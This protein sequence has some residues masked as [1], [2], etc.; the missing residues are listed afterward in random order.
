M[1]F[2]TV[3]SRSFQFDRLI[4]SVDIA[5]G[6]NKID[7]EIF[8]QIGTSN[9]KPKNF[10]YTDFLDKAD[11]NSYIEKCD[12]VITHGGTGVIINSVKKRKKVIAVPRLAKYNEVVDDHQVQLVREFDKIGMV[13]ACYDCE[14][15]SEAIQI[16]KS[17]ENVGYVSNTAR[18]I[19]S[20]ENFI[21]NMKGE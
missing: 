13:T 19:E 21:I 12:I 10:S 4:E 17:K 18:I 2:I 14:N 15:I 7:D 6:Q 20:I 16:A 11:F 5:V 8:A 9:Y 1:I 3:G